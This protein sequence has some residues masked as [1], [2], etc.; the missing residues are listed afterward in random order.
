M[1][2]SDNIIEV[3]FHDLNRQRLVFF[4]D[5]VEDHSVLLGKQLAAGSCRQILQVIFDFLLLKNQ[6][7]QQLFHK[8]VVCALCKQ[9]VKIQRNICEVVSFLDL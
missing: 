9:D 7:R 8:A 4:I 2:G 1:Q 6:H 5:R 3:F